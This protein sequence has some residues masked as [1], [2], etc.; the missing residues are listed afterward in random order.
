MTYALIASLIFG[1]MKHFVI[2]EYTGYVFLYSRMPLSTLN[3]P[4]S[5]FHKIKH[6]TYKKKIFFT[7]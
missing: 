3:N 5:N 7:N 1:M 2:W 4:D 6:K